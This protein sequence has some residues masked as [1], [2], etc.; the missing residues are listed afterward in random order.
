VTV[1]SSA[2][3]KSSLA[4]SAY[5][6]AT[7][8][9]APGAVAIDSGGTSHT[10]PS[11]PVSNPSSWAVNVW[12]DESSATTMWT[13]VPAGQTVRTTTAGTGNGHTSLVLT[14]SAGA[15]GTPAAGGLPAMADAAGRGV[16]FTVVLPPA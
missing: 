5:R 7:A 14:D 8:T 2:Y 9:A 6:G 3:A 11:L 12:A 15:V 13:G 16:T 10:T 4:L 1:Q